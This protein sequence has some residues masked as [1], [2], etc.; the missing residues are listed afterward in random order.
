[1]FKLLFRKQLDSVSSGTPEA[2]V[3]MLRAL[4]CREADAIWAV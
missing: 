3:E 1:M 2:N 4:R